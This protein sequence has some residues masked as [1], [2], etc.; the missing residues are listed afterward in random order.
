MNIRFTSQRTRSFPSSQQKR[1]TQFIKVATVYLFN[2][3]LYY[4][5][6]QVCYVTFFTCLC[7]LR[8]TPSTTT[9]Y[10]TSYKMAWLS[11][12]L[13]NI[14]TFVKSVYSDHN[15]SESRKNEQA[16]MRRKENP[17]TIRCE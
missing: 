11:C 16:S 5:V 4:F 12:C 3:A 2:G 10:K 6:S 1:T 7:S 13:G 17:I 15:I 9:K 8:R 14:N